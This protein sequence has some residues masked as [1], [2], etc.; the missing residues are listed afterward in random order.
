MT[1]KDDSVDTDRHAASTGS[2]RIAPQSNPYHLPS[3][4][5]SA[6]LASCLS[7]KRPFCP[8]RVPSQRSPIRSAFQLPGPTLPPV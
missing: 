2:S 6:I 1:V 3:D 8:A 5:P 4:I 7:I